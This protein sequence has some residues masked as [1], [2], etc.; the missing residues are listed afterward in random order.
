[1]SY[2]PRSSLLASGLL[3]AALLSPADA[4]SQSSARDRA[5]GFFTTAAFT[6]SSV[7][8]EGST[9]RQSGNGGT[10]GLGYSFTRSVAG[11]IEASAAGIG[12][13]GNKLPLV[14]M[15]VGARFTPIGPAGRLVPYLE[16]AMGVRVTER[17]EVTICDPACFTENLEMAGVSRTVGLGVLLHAS[18]S[19]ALTA[20]VRWTSGEFDEV[21]F[22]NSVVDGFEYTATSRR[23]GLGMQWYPG[24]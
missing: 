5:A 23:Y 19:L 15:D 9:H 22:R 3:A 16:A 21:A 17:D 10:A 8:A 6:V 24:R 7:R 12:S 20:N 4:H 1:M 13:P 18:A 2:V 14:H 11:F